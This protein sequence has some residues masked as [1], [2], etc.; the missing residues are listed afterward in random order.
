MDNPLAGTYL[1][2]VTDRIIMSPRTSTLDRSAGDAWY[3]VQLDNC[4]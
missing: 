1:D 2:F 4:C 3:T